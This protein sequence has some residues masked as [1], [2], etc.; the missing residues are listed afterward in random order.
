[1]DDDDDDDDEVLRAQKQPIST[2]RRGS[3]S[4]AHHK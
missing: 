1:M 3:V 2:V 4:N